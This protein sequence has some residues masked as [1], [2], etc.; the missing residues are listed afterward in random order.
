MKDTRILNIVYTKYKDIPRG[1][2]FSFRDSES[3]EV[4]VKVYEDT[5]LI[6]NDGCFVS[7]NGTEIVRPASQVLVKW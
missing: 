7:M 1:T 2:M 3:G 5:A 6:L 4:C